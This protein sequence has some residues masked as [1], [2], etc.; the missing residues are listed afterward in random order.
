MSRYVD[1]GAGIELGKKLRIKWLKAGE[2][3]DLVEE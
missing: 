2:V 3:Q 1:Q